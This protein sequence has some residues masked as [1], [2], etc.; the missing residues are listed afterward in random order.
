MNKTVSKSKKKWIVLAGILLLFIVLLLIFAPHG[1]KNYLI[2][3]MD[4]YGSLNDT[5]RSDTM[6]LVR[7]DFD[8]RKIGVVTFA[9]DLLL[10]YNGHDQK[11]NT[12]IR[13]GEEAGL[14][15]V[16]EENFDFKIDGWF[17]VNF[18]SLISI[19]DEIGG[20]S[21]ELTEAEAK[22]ITRNVGDYP[23]YPLS[24]GICRL[25]G[26]QA[27]SYARC[28]KLDNDFGRGDRQSKLVQALVKES[29]SMGIR[30]IL[31]VFNTMGHAWRSSLSASDQLHLLYSC[32]WM[33]HADIIRVGIP[34]EQTYWYSNSSSG[35]NGVL[36]NLD[37]NRQMLHELLSF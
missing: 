23:G 11:I 13:L 20:V 29:R 28:R 19:I 7:L 30:R 2:I 14:T 25:N 12:I 27:L 8:K 5:G 22:Y 31:Q 4:N 21:V 26:A 3:G 34:F 9:R 24:E 32:L 16:L 18:S 10:D 35:D 1:S 36:L 37:T 33:R 6:I 17:R 15:S